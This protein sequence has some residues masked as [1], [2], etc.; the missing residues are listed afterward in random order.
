MQSWKQAVYGHTAVLNKMVHNDVNC[1]G[2]E[3]AVSALWVFKVK[4][5]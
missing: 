4:P 1:G 5:H 2:N 3:R